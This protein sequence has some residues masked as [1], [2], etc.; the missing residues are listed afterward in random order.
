MHLGHIAIGK[1]QATADFGGA[2]RSPA[3]ELSHTNSSWWA[4]GRQRWI[5]AA[6]FFCFILFV[7]CAPIATKGAVTAFRAALLL[8]L[9]KILTER[10]KLERQPLALPLLLFLVFTTVSTIFSTEPL[11]SWGRMRGVTELTIALLVGQT[12]KNLRQVKILTYLLLAACLVSVGGQPKKNSYSTAVVCQA[13]PIGSGF[14][15]RTLGGP[16]NFTGAFRC[17]DGI[18]V[19]S[20]KHRRAEKGIGRRLATAWREA[21]SGPAAAC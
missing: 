15:C 7:L 3:E 18:S 21:G 13:G 6:L 5:D 10:R 16:R 12:L 20:F 1:S 19:C 11:L 9:A 4:I 17:M 14:E 2:V 8:W